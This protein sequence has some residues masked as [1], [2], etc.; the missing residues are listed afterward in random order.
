MRAARK[1]CILAIFSFSW[2]GAFNAQAAIVDYTLFFIDV[3]TPTSGTHIDLVRSKW[4][5][6]RGFNT[7]PLSGEFVSG[8]IV[9]VLANDSYGDGVV[10][11]EDNCTSVPN[12][13]QINTDGTDDGGDACDGDDDKDGWAD[14]DDNCSL[15]ANP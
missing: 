7:S 9:A 2:I 12:A 3:L 11:D 8:S 14:V 1:I 6:G 10:D 13:D 4:E 15:A 5:C